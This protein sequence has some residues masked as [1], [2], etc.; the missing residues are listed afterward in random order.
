MFML[1]EGDRD[2]LREL[3]AMLELSL[4]HNSGLGKISCTTRDWSLWLLSQHVTFA[5]F[6]SICP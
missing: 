6:L 5:H 2:F 3:L 4:E 1:Q